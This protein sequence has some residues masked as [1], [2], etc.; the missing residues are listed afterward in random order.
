MKQ[1]GYTCIEI[2]VMVAVIAGIVAIVAI[3][4]PRMTAARATQEA[5]PPSPP[6]SPWISVPGDA[7][8]EWMTVP[9]GR[10]YRTHRYSQDLAAVFVPIPAESPK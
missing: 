10:V 1:R 6:P 5:P 3:T 9:G 2:L 8:T 7:Q 4:V